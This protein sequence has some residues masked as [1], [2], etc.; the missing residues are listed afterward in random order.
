LFVRPKG[1][2]DELRNVNR[3]PA[4]RSTWSPGTAKRCERCIVLE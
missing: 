3:K 1:T 4:G 2:D